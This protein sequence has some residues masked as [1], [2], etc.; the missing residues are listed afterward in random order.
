MGARYTKFF[1]GFP[2]Y[3]SNDIIVAHNGVRA[4][5]CVNI[6]GHKVELMLPGAE[7]LFSSHNHFSFMQLQN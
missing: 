1:G 2:A 7:V 6:R 3:D 4:W 5:A